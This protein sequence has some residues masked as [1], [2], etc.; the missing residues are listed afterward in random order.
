MQIDMQIRH[1][2]STSQKGRENSPADP[3]KGPRTMHYPGLYLHIPFCVSKCSYCDFFSIIERDGIPVFLAALFKE[4]ILRRKVFE[5]FD[6]LYIG[7]GTPS[8][9]TSDQLNRIVAQLHQNFEILDE[10]EIT[11]EANPADIHVSALEEMRSLG[12]NRLNIGVQSFDDRILNFLGRRHNGNQAVQAIFAARQAGFDNFGIDLIYGI[13]GQ[14]R[15]TWKKTL[16]QAVSLNIPHLS[17]YQLTVEQE[18][19]LGRAYRQGL[20]EIPDNDEL[21]E[22]FMDTSEF[23]EE[24]GYCHYEVSNFASRESLMSRHNS[25][26][27]QHVPYLGLGPAAHSFDGEKRWWNVRSLEDYVHQL[28]ADKLPM[29]NCETLNGEELQLE[30]LFLGFRTK[31][32]VHL[33]DFAEKYGFD[34][35]SLKKTQIEPLLAEGHLII[36]DGRLQPTRRGMALADSLALL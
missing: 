20:F 11:L 31:A 3:G 8:V 22:W 29:E 28:N 35:L 26:Y 12:I 33:A 15:H 19:P 2:I 17:C 4:M 30:S 23:L 14:S 13:P 25:K 21:F 7:G 27:W 1:D 16:Q 5:S 36:T 9:L 18:T 10:A 34:L 6:T 24:S 32:G